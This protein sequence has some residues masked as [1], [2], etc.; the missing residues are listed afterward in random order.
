MDKTQAIEIFEELK[1]Y[2]KIAGY[3][4][5]NYEYSDTHNHRIRRIIL[6]KQTAQAL[7]YQ[8]NPRFWALFFKATNQLGFI[9]VIIMGKKHFKHIKSK[10]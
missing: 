3:I 5:A 1:T 2:N 7:G 10:V 4:S 8:I 6:A 9:P